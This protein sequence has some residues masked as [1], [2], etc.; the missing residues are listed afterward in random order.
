M[1]RLDP[2]V[3]DI[4]P[5]ASITALTSFIRAKMEEL[6]RAGILAPFSGGLDSSTVLL[7]CVQAVGKECV[8]ALL[9][10]EKQDNP[11]AERY[12]KQLANQH[13]IETI[14]HDISPI[15]ERLGVYQVFSHNL[16]N[17]L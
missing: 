1:I 14:T 12:A 3:F 10:P 13:Q 8:K 2:S 9:M 7:L 17:P 15:L 11:D 5:A 6:G 16:I 4:D